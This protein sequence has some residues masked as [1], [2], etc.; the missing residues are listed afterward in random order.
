MPGSFQL[1]CFQNGVDAFFFGSCDESARVDNDC[2]GP[3]WLRDKLK[4]CTGKCA[5]KNFRINRVLAAPERD[6]RDGADRNLNHA[7]VE[8]EVDCKTTLGA[9][10]TG[11][12]EVFVYW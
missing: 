6:N 4:P 12:L 10:V 9:P 8:C 1:D 11:A 3:L 2:I 7:R 5:S